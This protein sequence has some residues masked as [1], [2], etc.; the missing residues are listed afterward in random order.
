MIFSDALRTIMKSRGATQ[1]SLANTLGIKPPSVAGVLKKGNPS[2]NAMC[3]YL[4]P[5][6]YKVALVPDGAFLPEGSYTL[7][8]NRGQDA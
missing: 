4:A 6:G 1:E 2:V 3:N 7:E 8:P 5:L